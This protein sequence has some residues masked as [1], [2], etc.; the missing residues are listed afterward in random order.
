MTD[1]RRASETQVTEPATA[2]AAP[3]DGRAS[4][5]LREI[6]NAKVMS[7]RGVLWR[8]AGLATGVVALTALDVKPAKADSGGNFILGQSN[9]ADATT[10]LTPD[11]G[12]T[13]SPSPLMY[14]NGGNLNATASTLLVQGPPGGVGIAANGGS[15]SATT[16]GLAIHGTGAGTA[17]GILGSSTGGIGVRGTSS[18][19][20]G[21]HGTSTSGAGVFG[22]GAVGGYAFRGTGRIRFDQVSGVSTIAAGTTSKTVSVSVNV[23]SSSFVLLTAMNN[24]GSRSLWFTLDTPN[25]KITIHMS[26]SRGSNTKVG[27]LLL[28]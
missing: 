17:N 12:S 23:T 7:R 5:R 24:I 2:D 27:W 10:T 14:L 25:N 13:V 20:N 16:I 18:T 3:R 4:G 26:S 19:S 1:R 21:V 22:Q 28:R 8:A 15:L 9:D 11:S 6:E